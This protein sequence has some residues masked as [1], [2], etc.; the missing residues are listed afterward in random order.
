MKWCPDCGTEYTDDALFCPT[1][2]S[3]LTSSRNQPTSDPLIGTVVGDRY[4]VLERIGSGAMGSVYRARN[5]HAEFDVAIK[6]LRK[7]L[8]Q[9]PISLGV[10]K[11]KN[12]SSRSYDTPTS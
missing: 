7:Q 3:R 8:E 9:T 2:G 1:D 11:M 10:S 6:L 4:R 5:V 12:A